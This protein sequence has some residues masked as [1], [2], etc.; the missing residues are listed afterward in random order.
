MIKISFLEFLIRGIPEG[1][2][3]FLAVHAFAKKTIEIDKYLF[4]SMVYWINVYLIKFLTIQNGTYLILNVIVSIIIV[5]T[6]NK[7]EIIEA[8]KSCISS[9]ILLLGCEGMN[10]FLIQFILRKDINEVFEQRM[11]KIMYLSPS[12]VIFGCIAMYSY[13]RFIKGKELCR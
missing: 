11:L 8:I 9:T 1:L 3:F 10:V 13:I 12:L 6:I 4:S 5:I 7:I 2:V